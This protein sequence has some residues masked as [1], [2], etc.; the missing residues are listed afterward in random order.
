MGPMDPAS[1]FVDPS[2]LK[3]G[4]AQMGVLP[5]EGDPTQMGDDK[6]DSKMKA[7]GK[8]GYAMMKKMPVVGGVIGAGEDTGKLI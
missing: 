2:L 4:A 1:M 7:A 3:H 8:M 5:K 6:K